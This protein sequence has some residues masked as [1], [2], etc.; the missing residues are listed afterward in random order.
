MFILHGSNENC[1][2]YSK[3][4]YGAFYYSK[5]NQRH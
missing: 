4:D 3:C 2:E 1:E 5:L